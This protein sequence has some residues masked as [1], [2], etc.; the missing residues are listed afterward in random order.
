MGTYEDALGSSSDKAPSN[1]GTNESTSSEGSTKSSGGAG[2][3]DFIDSATTGNPET[4][5]VAFQDRRLAAEDAQPASSQLVTVGI[6]ASSVALLSVVVYKLLRRFQAKRRPS[7][8]P[9]TG[10]EL[11]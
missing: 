7:A 3:Q 5:I 11:A 6:V 10:E 2:L 1:D 9:V 4:G 8:T